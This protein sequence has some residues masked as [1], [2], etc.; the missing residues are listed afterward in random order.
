MSRRGPLLESRVLR[1]PRAA[2]LAQLEADARFRLAWL[3]HLANVLAASA[4][5]IDGVKSLEKLDRQ[6]KLRL[7]LVG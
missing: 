2:F 3:R 1:F 4:T 6:Q 5:P 7:R